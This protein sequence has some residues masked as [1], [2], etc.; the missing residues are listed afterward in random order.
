MNKYSQDVFSIGVKI[1]QIFLWIN[2][3]YSFT[4]DVNI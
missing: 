2:F 4:L 3:M 1:G